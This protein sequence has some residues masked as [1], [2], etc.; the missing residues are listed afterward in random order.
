[1]TTDSGGP[2]YSVAFSPDGKLLASAKS[3]NV[4]LWNLE[5]DKELPG[6]RG[7]SSDVMSVTFSPDGKLLASAGKDDIVKLSDPVTGYEFHTLKGHTDSVWSVA[8]RRDGKLL[9]S[10]SRD[11]SINLWECKPK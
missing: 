6:I 1:V 2:A 8:F 9:A 4:R 11:G 5:G 3:T 10:G 7:H